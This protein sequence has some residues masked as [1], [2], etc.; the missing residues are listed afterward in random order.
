[1]NTTQDPTYELKGQAKRLMAALEDVFRIEAS[2]SQVLDIVAR[3]HKHRDWKELQGLL[4]VSQAQQ[5]Q[6]AAK[7]KEQAKQLEQQATDREL[8]L[9]AYHLQVFDKN[10]ED[11]DDLVHDILS[12]R[13]A[14]E[15]NNQG[16]EAQLRALL[17]DCGTLEHLREH[18]QRNVQD[19]EYDLQGVYAGATSEGI[20][21]AIFD[22][23][24]WVIQA[25]PDDLLSLARSSR[26]TLGNCDAGDEVAFWCEKY[27]RTFAREDRQ[28]IS[29]FLRRLSVRNES[30]SDLLGM[31][32]RLAKNQFLDVC[33][34]R[35]GQTEPAIYRELFA[36]C[37]DL[38]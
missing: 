9:I 11:L 19:W 12:P 38:Y 6:A 25:A 4:S 31:T 30:Q 18:L 27:G 29:D 10:C 24:P 3:M 28:A 7:E 36:L 35:F 20:Q 16:L 26:G 1:M 21:P 15:V 8:E 2:H 33:R 14:S 23:L 34:I 5:S 17:E 37:K 32:V 22:A 13:E